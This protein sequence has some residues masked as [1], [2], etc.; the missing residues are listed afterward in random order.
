MV[1][2]V[3]DWC[4][5]VAEFE[6]CLHHGSSTELSPDERAEAWRRAI[7]LCQGDYLSDVSLEW[8]ERRRNDLQGKLAQALAGLAEWETARRLH[9]SAIVKRLLRPTAV[10]GHRL[11]PSTTANGPTGPG[12]TPASP[13]GVQGPA[14]RLCHGMLKEN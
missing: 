7:A 4:M 13:A 14:L 12:L 6:A 11:P 1:R 8:A 10:L 9:L 3:D 5:L 2:H